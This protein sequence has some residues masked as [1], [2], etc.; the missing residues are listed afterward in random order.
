VKHP[1]PRFIFALSVALLPFQAR[2]EAPSDWSSGLLEHMVGEATL[3]GRILGTMAH[4]EVQIEWVLNHQF[5]RI[6]EKT[7]PGAPAQE[8]R[9]EAN[10]FLGYDAT[11]NKYVLHLLDTFGGRFSETLGFGVRDGDT[12]RFVFEYPDGPFHTT[13][14]WSETSKTWQWVME[15]KDRAGTWTEFA[16]LVLKPK[17]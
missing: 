1:A 16:N 3:E 10:W 5:L 7:A 15:Q 4:H 8:R 6:C 2:A 17:R 9:Y 13:F 14:A 12:L 11:S